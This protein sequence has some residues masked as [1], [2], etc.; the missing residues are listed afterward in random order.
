MRRRRLAYGLAMMLSCG[1]VL[2]AS[3][4]FPDVEFATGSSEGGGEGGSPEGTT[5]DAISSDVHVLVDGADPSS[6]IV[7][8]AGG[9]IDAS[10]CSSCDCDGDGFNHA[11]CDAGPDAGPIDCDDNDTRTKPGQ[12]WLDVPG[13][14]PQFGDW[15]CVSG[16]E[17]FYDSNVDCSKVSAGKACDQTFGFSDN[18]ACGANGSLVTC[19]TSPGT[20]LPPVA[21]SCGVGGKAPAKQSCK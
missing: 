9:R 20:L 4:S 14:K 10:G 12:G 19:K 5:A 8:D 15:N 16:V 13:E 21:A 3:C 11:G 17:K 6:L 1:P 18:P 2:L 7:Q